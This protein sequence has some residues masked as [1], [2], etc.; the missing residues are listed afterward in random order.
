MYPS[1]LAFA[2]RAQPD[3]AAAPT[4]VLR[5]YG[6]AEVFFRSPRKGTGIDVVRSAWSE[7]QT[8]VIGFSGNSAIATGGCNSPVITVTET[9]ARNTKLFILVL[10][11]SSPK[12]THS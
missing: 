5:D 9:N 1:G 3:H 10:I 11:F 8:M 7:N 2:T 6:R 4:P 12:K